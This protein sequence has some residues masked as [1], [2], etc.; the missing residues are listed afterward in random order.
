MVEPRRDTQESSPELIDYARVIFEL[1][2]FQGYALSVSGM[3][4]GRSRLGIVQELSA[5]TLAL[6]VGYDELLKEDHSNREIIPYDYFSEIE[7]KLKTGKLVTPNVQIS[8]VWKSYLNPL[9][10]VYYWIGEIANKDGDPFSLAETDVGMPVEIVATLLDPLVDQE[11]CQQEWK[12]LSEDSDGFQSFLREFE[13]RVKDEG[14]N[15][16]QI[17]T[18]KDDDWYI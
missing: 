1:L 15:V 7:E 10:V 17:S 16:R 8:E 2:R 9:R 11:W 14:S 5:N 13:F 18:L 12:S 3:N 4:M 6:L